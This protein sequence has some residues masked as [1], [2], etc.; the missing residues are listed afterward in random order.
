M[1]SAGANA[2][3]ALART[4]A[5][6][7]R[8][9]AKLR[10][11]KAQYDRLRRAYWALKARHQ[12]R[13]RAV[14]RAKAEYEAILEECNLLRRQTAELYAA[15][16]KFAHVVQAARDY[17]KE[18]PNRIPGLFDC[19]TALAGIDMATLGSN[20]NR[21][22]GQEQRLLLRIADKVVKRHSART[23]PTTSPS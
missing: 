17:Q 1:P 11:T 21:L 3:R 4:Q 6:L 19:L 22:R 12:Y 23:A 18:A 8:A 20:G 7:A 15:F 9:Q 14:A 5:Q 13:R 16:H 10:R 2:R